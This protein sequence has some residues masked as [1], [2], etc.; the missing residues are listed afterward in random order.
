MIDAPVLCRL[1]K[2]TRRPPRRQLHKACPRP[3][4]SGTRRGILFI[5]RCCILVLF[6]RLGLALNYSVFY[7]EILNM[8]SEACTL[9]K[10][11]RSLISCSRLHRS[12]FTFHCCRLPS[13]MQSPSWTPS[14]RS[15]TRM[16]LLSCRCV[17]DRDMSPVVSHF[18]TLV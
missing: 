4:P 1:G 8:P 13:T 17:C 6:C 10:V 12:K 7:Y 18:Q 15:S 2:S 16:P 3:I 14:K 11:R 9:A 5:I